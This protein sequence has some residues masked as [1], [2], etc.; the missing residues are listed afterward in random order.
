MIKTVFTSIAFAAM[1]YG[2]SLMSVP[3]AFIIGGGVVVV[4]SLIGEFR[5]G[6]ANQA[7]RKGGK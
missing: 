7:D 4:A 1:V 6:P 5:A 3:W 2:V